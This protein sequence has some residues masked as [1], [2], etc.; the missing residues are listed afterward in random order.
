MKKILL[1]SRHAASNKHAVARRG[2]NKRAG[3]KHGSQK[4]R[5]QIKL[6]IVRRAENARRRVGIR[7]LLRKA[8]ERP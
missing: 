8:F 7:T 3:N 6:G 5:Y 2:K 4:N 1:F